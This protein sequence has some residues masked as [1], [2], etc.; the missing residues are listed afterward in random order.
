MRQSRYC[1]LNKNRQEW[2]KLCNYI[3]NLY[4]NIYMYIYQCHL[5]YISIWYIVYINVILYIKSPYNFS[6]RHEASDDLYSWLFYI[7]L[8]IGFAIMP[9]NCQWWYQPAMRWHI[10]LEHALTTR[11]LPAL[12]PSASLLC[13]I[14]ANS[15]PIFN[16]LIVTGCIVCLVCVPLFGMDGSWV[17]ISNYSLVCQVSQF[18]LS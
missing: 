2:T 12:M 4:I 10:P 15:L 8:C 14:V 9:W 17:S 18:Y 1:V 6:P 16:S 11:V 13:S 3:A 7:L 5:L